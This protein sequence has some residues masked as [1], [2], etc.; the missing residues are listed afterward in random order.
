MLKK[1]VGMTILIIFLTACAERA[2]PDTEPVFATVTPAPII[3]TQ[4]PPTFTLTAS[5]T[6][7]PTH[8][9]EPTLEPTATN[10]VTP[11]PVLI[12]TAAP[13]IDEHAED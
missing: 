2:E 5:P 10:T 6:L 4:P 9:L 1:L 13:L 3:P 8:T 11:L 7:T 12:P